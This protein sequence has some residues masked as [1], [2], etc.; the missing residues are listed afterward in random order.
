MDP[1]TCCSGTPQGYIVC[2]DWVGDSALVLITKENCGLNCFQFC[3]KRETNKERGTLKK[4]VLTNKNGHA[5]AAMFSKNDFLYTRLAVDLQQ[6]MQT[7]CIKLLSVHRQI[8]IR[9]SNNFVL[10]NL[11]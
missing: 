11:V 10:T 3:L 7:T 8:V 6:V 1:V 2:G 4:I 9:H 5:F